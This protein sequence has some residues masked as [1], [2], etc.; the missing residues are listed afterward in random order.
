MRREPREGDK[1]GCL[2]LGCVC[3][4]L[5]GD[6]FEAAWWESFLFWT[7]DVSM[8]GVTFEEPYSV[9]PTP[10]AFVELVSLS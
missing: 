8:V 4:P 10:W 7:K 5:I 2:L 1:P 6:G 3:I 9:W